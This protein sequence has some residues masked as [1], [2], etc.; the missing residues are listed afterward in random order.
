MREKTISLSDRKNKNCNRPLAQIVYKKDKDMK[1][2][3]RSLAVLFLLL[4]GAGGIVNARTAGSDHR[5]ESSGDL[6]LISFLADPTE[7]GTLAAVL[8]ANGLAVKAARQQLLA[9][10]K[11]VN[12]NLDTATAPTS[13]FAAAVANDKAPHKAAIAKLTSALEN[14][15]TPEHLQQL[16]HQEDTKNIDRLLWK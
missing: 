5:F 8:S 14:E 4:A 2:W 12:T 9:D 3:I 1:K 13:A 7:E 11:Q 10:K 15:F 16:A 6:K